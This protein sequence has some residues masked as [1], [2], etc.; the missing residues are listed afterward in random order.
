MTYEHRPGGAPASPDIDLDVPEIC[1]KC[2]RDCPEPCEA[3]K[4]VVAVKKNV[5]KMR[6]TTHGTWKL[7]KLIDDTWKI[8][9]GA[10]A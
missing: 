3:L 10:R 5:G 6:T 9:E 2:D 8:L 4:R 1:E 7:K